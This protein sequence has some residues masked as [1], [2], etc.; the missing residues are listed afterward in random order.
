VFIQLNS[1]KVCRNIRYLRTKR[2]MTQKALAQCLR[3]EPIEVR[4]LESEKSLPVMDYDVLCRVCAFFGVGIQDLM[5]TD[6]SVRA[7]LNVGKQ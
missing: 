7:R 6:L 4:H 2:R 5:E 1:T 3:I